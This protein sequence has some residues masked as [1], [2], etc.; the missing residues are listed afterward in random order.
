[1]LLDICIFVILQH[2]KIIKLFSQLKGTN[3]EFKSLCSITK[4]IFHKT[5][6]NKWH[7]NISAC[8]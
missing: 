8:P 5:A 4:N 6:F 1:M 3:I 7:F 2:I